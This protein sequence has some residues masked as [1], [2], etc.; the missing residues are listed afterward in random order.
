L[1]D[2]VVAGSVG[3]EGASEVLD[4]AVLAPAVLADVAADPEALMV[5]RSD[6]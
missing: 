6:R 5:A 3:L 2:L 1:A 4:R